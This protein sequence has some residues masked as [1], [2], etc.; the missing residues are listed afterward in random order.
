MPFESSASAN[1]ARVA[2][3]LGSRAR[4]E[5]AVL[6]LGIPGPFHRPR[7]GPPPAS[8]TLHAKIRS[9]CC[10]SGAREKLE[11]SRGNDP[12][13]DAYKATASPLMLAG[14]GASVGTRTR[15]HS[16]ATSG[17]RLA[18][19]ACLVVL[20]GIEPTCTSYPFYDVSGRG[21]TARWHSYTV[22]IRVLHLERMVS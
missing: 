6:G 21:D 18:A 22:T 12:R 5:L 19:K 10:T 20:V 13:S 1:C 15:F 16:L 7:V 11:P 9:L 2:L 8:R 4:V 14:L 3:C 17:L